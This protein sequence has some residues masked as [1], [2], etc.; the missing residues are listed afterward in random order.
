[1]DCLAVLTVSDPEQ[2]TPSATVTSEA[3][4]MTQL[5]DRGGLTRIHPNISK[6]FLTLESIFR[7]L[8]NGPRQQLCF[9][10]FL[11]EA[12]KSDLI[13]ACLYDQMYKVNATEST[14]EKIF[15]GIVKS[16]FTVRA[17]HKCKT[18]MDEHRRK[19]KKPKKEKALRKALADEI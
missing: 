16:Y 17:H 19:T 14:M 3:R 7:F 15:H 10:T 12:S 1:M 4:S 2:E 8:F 11:S 18:F 9:R 5:L 13:L 6:V